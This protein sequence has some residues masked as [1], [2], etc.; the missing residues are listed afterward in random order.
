MTARLRLMSVLVIGLTLLA[1]RFSQAATPPLLPFNNTGDLFALEEHSNSILRFDREDGDA[2]VFIPGSRIEAVTGGSIAF[3]DIGLAVDQFGALYFAD[4][5]TDSILKATPD[6]NVRILTIEQAILN[7][8][9]ATDSDPTGLAIGSDG[10]LYV[11]ED[12]TDAV[13]RVDPNN[14]GV[15]VIATKNDFANAVGHETIDFESNIVA[16]EGGVI[17][18]ASSHENVDVIFRLAPPDYSEPTVLVND[19]PAFRSLRGYMT[20]AP[21]GDL[22]VADED[23]DT[24]YRV[25]PGGAVGVFLSEGQL[26]AVSG[27]EIGLSGG[28]AFDSA[29]NFYVGDHTGHKILRFNATLNSG[30]VWVDQ[31]DVEDETN[32]EGFGIQTGIAFGLGPRP[33]LKIYVPGVHRGLRPGEAPPTATPTPIATATPTPSPTPEVAGADFYRRRGDIEYD[34]SYSGTTLV[35]TFYSYDG[36]GHP[37]GSLFVVV[38]FD[39]GAGCY[40]PS[41]GHNGDN[42][43]YQ[44]PIGGPGQ[45]IRS[46]GSAQVYRSFDGRPPDPG[47]EN[48]RVASNEV[49]FDTSKGTLWVI[50]WIECSTRDTSDSCDPPSSNLFDEYRDAGDL[51]VSGATATPE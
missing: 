23:L 44:V 41:F 27:G 45:Q 42:G 13:L 17:Y 20:R 49:R 15:A 2:N 29:G 47:K 35:G 22:I 7:V 4:G 50:N 9:G 16:A 5:T 38:C 11:N 3:E 46:T 37:P 34:P 10:F 51:K 36:V 32:T 48:F 14:G 26:E 8:T 12:R 6:G 19:P 24:I 43:Q 21:N 40:V 28:M 25:T 39:N 1:W 31:D 33:E 18:V 30:T